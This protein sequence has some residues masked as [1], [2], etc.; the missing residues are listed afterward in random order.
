LVATATYEDVPP[1]STAR[2]RW[3]TKTPSAWSMA[4]AVAVW[5]HHNISSG[6]SDS[7]AAGAALL[8]CAATVATKTLAA[9]AMAGAQTTINNPLKA[10]DATA[11]EMAT[12]T[13]IKM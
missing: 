9:T 8:L 11:T 7:R 12:T 1:I 3:D 5:P 13:T 10:T 6:S 4:A 2:K